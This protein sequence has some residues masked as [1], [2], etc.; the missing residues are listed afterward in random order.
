MRNIALIALLATAT[1]SSF[2]APA[3][4]RSNI[5][6]IVHQQPGV[7]FCAPPK[8][9]NKECVSWGPAGAGQLF[10]PCLKYEM[11]CETPANIQ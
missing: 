10:G 5:T 7:H 9:L 4:A 8:V 3:E 1:V 6:T 11:E 2:G